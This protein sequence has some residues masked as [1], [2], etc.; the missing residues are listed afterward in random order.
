MFINNKINVMSFGEEKK[1]GGAPLNLA[2]RT[3]SYGFSVAMISAVGNDEDGKVIRNYTKEN[4]LETAGN[5]CFS[6]I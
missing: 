3:A 6:G 5:H 2:L 1:I 4:A